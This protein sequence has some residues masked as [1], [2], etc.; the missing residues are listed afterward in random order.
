M[1]KKFFYQKLCFLIEA[2][3]GA[4]KYDFRKIVEK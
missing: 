4:L 1:F 3:I 2:E